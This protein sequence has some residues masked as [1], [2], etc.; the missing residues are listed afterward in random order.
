M[1]NKISNNDPD[2]ITFNSNN[3]IFKIND[4]K[5]IWSGS[6]CMIF[7]KSAMDFKNQ[8]ILFKYAKK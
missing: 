5:S 8:E 2:K 3:K 7:I 6:K 1:Q 4:K